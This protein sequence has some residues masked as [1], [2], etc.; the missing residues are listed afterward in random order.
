MT[1]VL[2]L[3]YPDKSEVKY[4]LFVFNDGE[5]CV[6]VD[7]TEEDRKNGAIEVK[8]RIRNPHEL[9]N[10]LIVCDVLKRQG[11]NS[12]VRCFYLMSQRMDRV[13]DFSMPYSLN[14]VVNL[15]KGYVDDLIVYGPHNVHKLRLN[16]ENVGMYVLLSDIPI[17]IPEPYLKD[18]EDLM[19]IYADESASDKVLVYC[20]YKTT[21]AIKK[22]R[23]SDGFIES[24][25]LKDEELI[26]NHKGSFL[27]VDDLCDGGMTFKLL[28]DK[29][30]E[31]GV[32]DR[33]DIFVGH[34]VNPK[35][36]ELLKSLYR[37][38]IITNSYDD[39]KTED[40]VVVYDV[41]K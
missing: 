36:L 33:T 5:P 22:R 32:L 3:I 31:L 4:D 18:N 34:M 19:V 29:L 14:V 27:V 15:L 6:K 38:V 40:N 9:Y 24:Y 23:A 28:S 13:M 39:Y 41:I 37:T 7:V 12:V 1:R 8:C 20:K 16:A 30:K 10:L 35:G 2:D 11:V 21:Y 17:E 26:K 25:S